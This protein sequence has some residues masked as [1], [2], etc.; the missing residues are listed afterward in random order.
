MNLCDP[1]S[2]SDLQVFCDFDGTV[3]LQDIGNSF[4]R[5][6]GLPD[7]LKAEQEFLAGTLGSREAL[8]RQ[9]R[10]LD[11]SPEDLERFIGENTELDPTFRIF[12]EQARQRDINVVI[13][14]DGVDLYIKPFLA[15]HGL[16]EVTLFTNHGR[17]QGRH[18]E[19]EF[20]Y[21]NSVCAIC[22]NCKTSHMERLRKP[23][24]R[25]VYVGDGWSDRCAARHA[26]MLFAKGRL[27]A[28]CEQEKIPHFRFER[29]QDVRG[30][31]FGPG[32][33]ARLRRA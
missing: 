20:P 24:Q 10:A 3:C 2:S 28:F 31:L 7:W 17:W 29:F 9:Y 8:V 27:R 4:L 13:L 22:G 6:F 23:G 11:A 32:G 26:D 18:I 19:L 33:K 15:R 30:V 21:F 12:L 1:S 14:S 16:Q 25:V 5:K